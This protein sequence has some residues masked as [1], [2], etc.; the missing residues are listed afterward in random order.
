MLAETEAIEA[1]Y[2]GLDGC[3]SSLR[4]LDFEDRIAELQEQ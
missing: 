4:Y 2:G 3:A 1:G